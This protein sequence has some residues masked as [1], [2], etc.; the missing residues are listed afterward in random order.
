MRFRD[1]IFHF[2]KPLPVCVGRAVIRGADNQP[3]TVE[4]A[5][6]SVKEH[7]CRIEMGEI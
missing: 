2:G 3:Y 1:A 5:A 4:T 6:I 7:T